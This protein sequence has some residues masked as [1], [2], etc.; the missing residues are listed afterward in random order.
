MI[1]VMAQERAQERVR[2][3]RGVRVKYKAQTPGF[4]QNIN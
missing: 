2:E 3:E 1:G 4:L